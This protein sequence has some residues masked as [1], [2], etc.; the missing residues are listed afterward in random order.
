MDP[1]A[2][3]LCLYFTIDFEGMGVLQWQMFVMFF[4][5]FWVTELIISMY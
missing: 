3:N 4:G 5:L 2:E 1:I